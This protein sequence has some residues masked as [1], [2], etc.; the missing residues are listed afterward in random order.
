MVQHDRGEISEPRLPLVPKSEHTL[1]VSSQGWLKCQSHGLHLQPDEIAVA[2]VERVRYFQTQRLTLAPP[3][4]RWA[5]KIH[6]SVYTLL[7]TLPVLRTHLL[8][9]IVKPR[10]GS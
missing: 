1:F 3:L 7:N 6:P 4:A 8:A 5:V 2:A 9:W 10:N